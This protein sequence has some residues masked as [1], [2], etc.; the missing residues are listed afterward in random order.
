MLHPVPERPAGAEWEPQ[1]Q[2]G[3]SLC[4]GF[5]LEDGKR[6]HTRLCLVT[7]AVALRGCKVSVEWEASSWGTERVGDWGAVLATHS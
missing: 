6:V 3:C 5:M 1:P 2:H 4:L 7:Q